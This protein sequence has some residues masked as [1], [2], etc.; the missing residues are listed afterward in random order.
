MELK[1][2]LSYNKEWLAV[3]G[4]EGLEGNLVIPSE[5]V[6]EGNTYPVT[7]IEKKAFRHQLS[8]TSVTIPVSMEV[9]GE[10]AFEDCVN[11]VSVRLQTKDSLTIQESAFA[12]CKALKEVV[13]PDEGFLTIG[14][15]AFFN[16]G[17]EE[18]YIPDCVK[19][20]GE[21]VFCSPRLRAFKT[22][23]SDRF[24]TND[25]KNVLFLREVHQLIIG[26]TPDSKSTYCDY[27]VK[28]VANAGTKGVVTLPD[29]V[30]KIEA[31]AFMECTGLTQVILPETIVSV[32]PETFF[33]CENLETI[34]MPNVKEIGECAFCGCKSLRE[35]VSSVPFTL[36]EDRA[37]ENCAS[38][39]RITQRIEAKVLGWSAFSDCVKLTQ[40][41][42][43]DSVYK[44]GESC[45]SNCSSLTSIDIPSSVD[46]IDDE[47]FENCSSLETIAFSDPN[48]D[49]GVLMGDRI[50]DGCISLRK[51]IINN[52]SVLEDIGLPEGVEIV[53][54]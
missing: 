51:I 38:L 54:P 40:I 24:F 28:A 6:F 39:T 44:I 47:A 5:G 16:C 33:W 21:C 7:M 19:R 42:L 8:L 11:I 29:F 48:G 43:A 25:S 9:I 52:A 41:N 27:I 10:K 4:G 18:I 23:S 13:F 45:F 26:V 1:Y 3:T 15:Y 37:F 14:D 49:Y 22:Q 35:I 31:G 20:I 30:T 17:M 50:F 34:V 12:G 32:A 46:V 2:R 36:I 53:K